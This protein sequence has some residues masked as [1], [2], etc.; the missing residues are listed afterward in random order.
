MLIKKRF[1]VNSNNN[2]LKTK[3]SVLDTVDLPFLDDFSKD[4]IYPDAAF[5]LDSNVFINRN[6][7][8]APPTLGVATFDGV[9]KSGCPYDTT[10]TNPGASLSADTLTSK[11]INLSLLPSDSV[12]FSFLWQA[13]GR[14]NDPE[15]D[16]SLVL[17]FFNPTTKIWTNMWS[18]KGYNPSLGDTT[19]RLVIIPVTDTA[20]LKNAFQFR[21]RNKATVSGNVDHWHIDYVLLDKNRNMNDTIFDDVAFAY[22]SRSLLKNYYAMPWEQ[23]QPSEMKTNLNFLIRNN[24]SVQKNTSFDYTI[25]NNSGSTEATYTGGSDNCLPFATNSYWNYPPI[26]NPPIVN[27]STPYSFLP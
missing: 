27:N 15:Q 25:F 1:D 23:Y 10:L 18:K 17:D 4:N 20:F 22:N 26:T 9:S 12:Y 16:D 24:N 19:F 21:F 3:S 7:P 11:P 2:A 8:I 6:L 5:W 14:G 13:K